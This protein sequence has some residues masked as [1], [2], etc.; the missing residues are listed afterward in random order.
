MRRVILKAAVLLSVA[1]LASCGGDTKEAPP[2]PQPQPQAAT[3]VMV[4]MVGSNLESNNQLS[5]TGNLKEM[6]RTSLPA[7]TNVV[8][9]TGG[10]N[11]QNNPSSPVP[12][13]I[14]VKRHVL[15]GGRL[16]E[17]ADLGTPDM[18]A[19]TTLSDFISWAGKTYPATN[20][21]LILWD[22]GGGWT[23]Y[24]GDENK[25]DALGRNSMLSLTSL[26]TALQTGTSNGA[27]HFD[28]IGF[29]AC[30]MATVEVAD[31]LKPYGDF[32]LASQELEPGSGWNWTTV[33]AS[34]D[35]D[36]KTFGKTVADAYVSKQA[37][38]QQFG[39]LSLIDLTKVAS[40][41]RSIES[42]SGSVLKEVQGSDTTWPNLVWKR[43]VSMAFGGTGNGTDSRDD[44][45]LVDI[46]QFSQAIGDT[47]P[48]SKDV[49]NAVS[50]AVIYR[51][52][53]AN[54]SSASGLSLYFPSRSLR[55]TQSSAD[56]QKS[57]AFS[58]VYRSFV[59]N[60]VA[61][62]A[63]KP[64]VWDIDSY[65]GQG[66]LVA[67]A[68]S[69]AGVMFVDTLLLSSVDANGIATMVGSMPTYHSN[70][71]AAKITV[72]A[73][74]SGNWLTLRGNP[75]ILG[76]IGADDNRQYWGVPIELNDTLTYLIYTA[77]PGTDEQ[78]WTAIGTTSSLKDQVPRLMPLPSATDR[79]R[80]L[81]AKIDTT[82]AQAS[83]LLPSTPVF[84]ASNF[85][86]SM[87]A[88]PAGYKQA[89]ML[90]DGVWSTKVSTVYSRLD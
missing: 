28:V 84:S 79:I 6:L 77:K 16:Q 80:L 2:Q 39:T 32:L 66:K 27:V 21:K 53:T 5:A 90:T 82:T 47:T 76:Y 11:V 19:A 34:A 50:D 35:Q 89:A 54:Y 22:H 49:A 23:G 17:V 69:D 61:A 18:G 46:K 59:K 44:L 45:D 30:L 52:A 36:A 14:N 29:D 56:Y 72:S 55:N 48:G 85:D 20:Y 13:W 31:A 87:S 68:H 38:E 67:D 71:F 73:P 81:A 40:V 43:A 15:L 74:L 86:L 57:V 64:H 10:A 78:V 75:V 33:I 51:N 3:T 12:N 1:C 24:G 26:S 25:P 88:V 65:V 41:Q 8:I 37:D 4:Y 7:N 42:W 70:N 9:E 58:P 83:D 60:Y 63:Q 62:L